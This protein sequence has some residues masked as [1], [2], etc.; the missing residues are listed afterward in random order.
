[1]TSF[2][3]A[4]VR[5]LLFFPHIALVNIKTN[6]LVLYIFY[7]IEVF[8]FDTSWQSLDCARVGDFGVSITGSICVVISL[9]AVNTFSFDMRH[10][11]NFSHFRQSLVPY[12]KIHGLRPAV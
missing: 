9:H 6:Q 5:H 7:S 10:C 4:H 1:M 3:H 12:K 2:F 11:S 8:S